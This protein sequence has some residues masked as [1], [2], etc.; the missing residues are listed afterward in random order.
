MHKGSATAQCLKAHT[1]KAASK[2]AQGH[3]LEG[4]G[5]FAQ[6]AVAHFGALAEDGSPQ[7]ARGHG[8]KEWY[9]L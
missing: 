3:V 6:L 7:K 8:L 2:K 1:G 5:C 9:A 4:E